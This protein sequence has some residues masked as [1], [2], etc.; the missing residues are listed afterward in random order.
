MKNVRHRHCAIKNSS[1]FLFAF[2][3]M[4][5]ADFNQKLF[6][7][8]DISSSMTPWAISWV[9][10]HTQLPPHIAPP[11]SAAKQQ[12]FQCHCQFFCWLCIKWKI[13]S[14]CAHDNNDVNDDECRKDSETRVRR[15]VTENRGKFCRA[16]LS[17][18]LF[19][20]KEKGTREKD[21]EK[22]F[23][24]N[25]LWVMCHIGNFGNEWATLREGMRYKGE[26]LFFCIH[27]RGE[28][29]VKV[30]KVPSHLWIIS[31]INLW[32]FTFKQ[33]SFCYCE[34]GWSV[35]EI[36][37]K[38]YLS[39]RFSSPMFKLSKSSSH[40]RWKCVSGARLETEKK[41]WGQSEHIFIRTFEKL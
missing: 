34:L 13:F 28:G 33:K 31:H 30:R 41:N 32:K 18:P 4:F 22:I 16:V 21:T 3:R 26:L 36:W 37:E 8:V 6:A 24:D 11:Q 5:V 2:S 12:P 20:P 29:Q 9:T 10:L 25:F 15:G 14:S 39:F 1:E 35:F 38:R 23:A 17:Q 19:R 27:P 40:N 7:I